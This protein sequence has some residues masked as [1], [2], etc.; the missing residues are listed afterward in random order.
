M[1]KI[2]LSAAALLLSVCCMAQEQ[3]AFPF[4]GG[5]DIMTRFFKENLAASPEIIQKKATGTVIFKFTADIKGTITKIVIY[6]ADD[7]VLVPP[8]IEAL[9]KSNHKWIIPDHEKSNDFI[10]AFSYSFNAPETQSAELR[11]AVYD[12]I[13]NR[14]PIFSTDQIPLNLATLLPTVMINYDVQ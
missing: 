7:A 14:K 4:Q 10:L 2:I 9:K 11:K 12:Y 5:K 6:Y 1:K 13:T 8:I 3:L